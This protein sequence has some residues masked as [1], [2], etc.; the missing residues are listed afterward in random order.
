M[1]GKSILHT[2]RALKRL[3]MIRSG[4]ETTFIVQ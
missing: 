4:N 1:T 2:L 3:K